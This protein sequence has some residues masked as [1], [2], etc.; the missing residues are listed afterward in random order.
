MLKITSRI[1]P[2]MPDDAR[3]AHLARWKDAVG[4]ARSH[5]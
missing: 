3:E 4:R 5:A 2:S 1:E